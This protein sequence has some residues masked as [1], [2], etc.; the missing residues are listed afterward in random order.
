MSLT[1]LIRNSNDVTTPK[2]PPPP[3]MAQ[4]RSA[5]SVVARDVEAAVGGHHVRGE[6]VVA[7]Q[8]EAP[9]EVADAAAQSQPANPGRGNDAARGG[10]TERVSCG[11]QVAPGGAALDAGGLSLRVD[12]DAPHC[13]EV[14][15]QRV[16]R[17]TEARH[18][19]G[20][21]AYRD[22]QVV[23]GRESY[24]THH[25][26]GVGRAHDHGRPAVDHGVVDAARLVVLDVL[27]GGHGSSNGL[28]QGRQRIRVHEQLLVS[29]LSLVA[30]G[31]ARGRHM[32]PRSAA[33]SRWDRHSR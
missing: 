8:T 1:G 12:A 6:K 18:A 21:A 15:D 4:K 27:R 9:G 28:T 20:P 26:A 32:P 14:D 24:G 2:L 30:D 25:V 10:Q 22:G 16:V 17:R 23:L 11:V 7:G 33:V 13:R 3:R 31:W 5:S 29:S 19:V